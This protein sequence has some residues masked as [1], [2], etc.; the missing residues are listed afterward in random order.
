[1]NVTPPDGTPLSLTTEPSLKEPGLYET[2]VS[3][4]PSGPWRA[5]VAVTD[6]DGQPLGEGAT[7]W[8]ADFAAEELA[9]VAPNR[10]LLE[11]IAKETGGQVVELSDLASF[12]ETL[13]NR[14]APLTETTTTPLWH[15]PLVWMLIV[16]G[17][18]VEWGVRRRRGL[19]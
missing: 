6:P 15:N 16:A 7:G 8:A 10:P 14:E 4:R 17:L 3:S 12:V 1:V 5:T 11:R 13:P 19:P 9:R 2:T 18:C